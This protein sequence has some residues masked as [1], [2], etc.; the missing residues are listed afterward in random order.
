ME[1]RG[2]IS[3]ATYMATFECISG[4]SV[5]LQFSDHYPEVQLT[6]A[7]KGGGPCSTACEA[8]SIIIHLQAWKESF[9]C[10]LNI[11]YLKVLRNSRP[12]QA[13]EGMN[14]IGIEIRVN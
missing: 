6:N 2:Q 11:S 1:G 4:V 3:V 7:A 10:L 5:G 9:S 8:V 14:G 13:T 12:Q